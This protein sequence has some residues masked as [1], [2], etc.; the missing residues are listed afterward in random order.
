[1][2]STALLEILAGIDGLDA[3]DSIKRQI[4]QLVAAVGISHGVKRLQHDERVAFARRLLDLRV[5][6]PTIR[7]RLIARYS[8][9]TRQAYRVID[10]ALQERVKK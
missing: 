10:E 4:R 8:I 9:S 1:M 7:D 2:R 5:S 6:R 3:D